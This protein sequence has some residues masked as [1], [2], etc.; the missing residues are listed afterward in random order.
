M[1]N[2]GFY[3]V[4]FFLFALFYVTLNIFLTPHLIGVYTLWGLY[5]LTVLVYSVFYLIRYFN[6]RRVE[7]IQD[8]PEA[9][10]SLNRGFKDMKEGRLVSRNIPKAGLDEE[11]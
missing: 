3:L 11:V 5:T 8:S 2:V 10:A 9:M 7:W 1:K 6:R 4:I